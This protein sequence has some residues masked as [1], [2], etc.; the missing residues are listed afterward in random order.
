MAFFN[1]TDLTKVF[2]SIVRAIGVLPV[3]ETP[4]GGGT[5]LQGNADGHPYVD[6][7]TQ[8]SPKIA[9]YASIASDTDLTGSGNGACRQI[10]I[11]TSGDLEV[12]VGGDTVVIPSDVVDAANGVLDIRATAIKSASTTAAKILVLW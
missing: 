3:V 2:Y 9:Y 6:G 12:V 8:P 11:G 7:M 5:N 4:T 1:S 10:I